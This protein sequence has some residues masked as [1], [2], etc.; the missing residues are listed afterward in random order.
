M[1]T[2]LLT[3]LIRYGWNFCDDDFEAVD[4]DDIFMMMILRGRSDMVSW[5]RFWCD[6]QLIGES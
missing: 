6:I 4:Y 5:G 2:P 1:K 3:T